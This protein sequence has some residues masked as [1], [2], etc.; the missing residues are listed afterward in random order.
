M[1]NSLSSSALKYTSPLSVHK[2]FEPSGSVCTQRFPCGQSAT[3]HSAVP[4]G[5]NRFTNDW[6]TLVNL[7]H[8]RRLCH[9]ASSW[10]VTTQHSTLQHFILSKLFTVNWILLHN[11]TRCSDNYQL[12]PS[13]LPVSCGLLFR[14]FMPSVWKNVYCNVTKTIHS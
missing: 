10:T 11:T 9:V 13:I 4:S 3:C 7:S 12:I 2:L 1:Y 6:L 5:L 8:I 14:F